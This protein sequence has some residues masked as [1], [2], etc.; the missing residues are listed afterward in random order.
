[1]IFLIVE[2]KEQSKIHRFTGNAM[3]VATKEGEERVDKIG[4]G[5]QKV[6]WFSTPIITSPGKP[7]SE[8]RP[9]S[10]FSDGSSNS[11]YLSIPGKVVF[12]PCILTCLYVLLCFSISFN[13]L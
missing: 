10:A 12:L 8:V 2:S 7:S 11:I 3:V 6:L 4:K 9:D 5:D 1:M 13:N